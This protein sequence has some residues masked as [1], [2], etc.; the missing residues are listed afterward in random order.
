M[1]EDN[2]NLNSLATAHYVVGGIMVLFSCLPLVHLAIGLSFILGV[3]GRFGQ[4]GEIPPAFFGWIFFL[5]GL[6]AF[7]VA[8]AVS[9]SVIVSGHFLK[10]RKNYM[11]TF[12]L[13]CVACMFVP[14]GTV[15][16]IFTIMVLSRDSVKKIYEER[17][18]ETASIDGDKLAN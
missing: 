1:D 12:I 18:G 15:L 9:I 4:T 8:Q 17:K 14:L 2:S 13:A 5:A 16:G 11:F 6:V 3:H 7:L 10:Q